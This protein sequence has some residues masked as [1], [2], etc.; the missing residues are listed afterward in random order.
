LQRILK[1]K[2]TTLNWEKKAL[3]NANIGVLNF[4]APLV[5]NEGPIPQNGPNASTSLNLINGI[6]AQH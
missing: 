3:E 2:Y 1:R 6:K 5:I 4:E